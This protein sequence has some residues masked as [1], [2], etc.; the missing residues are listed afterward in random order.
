MAAQVADVSPLTLRSSYELLPPE[1][2]EL[3]VVLLGNHWRQRCFVESILVET[4]TNMDLLHRIQ[5][6]KK[7]V[8]FKLVLNFVSFCLE[9]V[10]TK[11]KL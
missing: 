11:R 8:V 9:K 6:N 10:I 7:E 3:I 5:Q 1:M 2:S 4:E